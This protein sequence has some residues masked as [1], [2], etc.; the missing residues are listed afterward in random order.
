M[1]LKSN[2]VT[3]P[4]EEHFHGNIKCYSKA[5]SQFNINEA[6]RIVRDPELNHTNVKTNWRSQT[7]PIRTEITEKKL[8]ED[9]GPDSKG[10]Q[11]K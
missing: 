3:A 8:G 11:R 9:F 6:D 1:S 10:F 4:G 2:N 5:C 7:D